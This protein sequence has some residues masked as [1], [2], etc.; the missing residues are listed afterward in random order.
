MTKAVGIYTKEND[1]RV[2]A[3][4]KI[5]TSRIYIGVEQRE[6]KEKGVWKMIWSLIEVNEKI[7]QERILIYVT[8]IKWA[9]PLCP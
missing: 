3:D 2:I 1:S 4:I 7:I 9:G 5:L 8:I 6:N